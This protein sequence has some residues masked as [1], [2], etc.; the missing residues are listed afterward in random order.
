MPTTNGRRMQRNTQSSSRMVTSR[1][2]DPDQ[3]LISNVM[4]GRP[5]RRAW[6]SG[7]Q[8]AAGACSPSPSGKH[9]PPSPPMSDAAKPAIKRAFIQAGGRRH[10]RRQC[11]WSR[12]SSRP[13]ARPAA[14]A[15]M[16]KSA[17]SAG[18]STSRRPASSIR[19]WSPPMTAS[20]PSSRS[21]STPARHATIGIDL[22]AMCVND[23][24]VQGAE[25]LFFLD[26]FATG[27]LDVA[28]GHRR[29]SRASPRAAAWPAAR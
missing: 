20:A 10:R 3:Q 18:C 6:W 9:R 17:A 7:Y 11:P 22:V 14:P 23:I 28:A 8:R 2:A 12:P 16:P 27:K 15:P 25:P 13:C 19:C 29:S 5:L 1:K 24:V 4:A 26:Y 21:P